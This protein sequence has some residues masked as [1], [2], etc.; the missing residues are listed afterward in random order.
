[1]PSAKPGFLVTKR[2]RFVM[3]HG[4]YC[5][6][7]I[8]TSPDVA[9]PRCRYHPLGTV[10]PQQRTP[11]W[12]DGPAPDTIDTSAVLAAAKWVSGGAGAPNDKVGE[13][14]DG[15][16]YTRADFTQAIDKDDQ[17][18]LLTMIDGIAWQ[19]Y[20]LYHDAEDAE[21]MAHWDT[22]SASERGLRSSEMLDES[23]LR[24]AE[25]QVSLYTMVADEYQQRGVRSHEKW[26]RNKA[27]ESSADVREL[28]WLLHLPGGQQPHF[29]EPENLVAD[30]HPAMRPSQSGDI[31]YDLHV[32]T[33]EEEQQRQ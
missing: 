11:G 23:R 31:R 10:G 19:Q 16:A 8:K 22:D 15:R 4:G 29:P 21:R 24:Q 3:P 2:C 14:A 26:Y 5:G 18:A 1:M 9:E 28:R 6:R 33:P 7:R 17:H 30:H 13:D 32:P 12:N 25:A 20:L 27:A